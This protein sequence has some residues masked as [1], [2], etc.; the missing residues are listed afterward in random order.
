VD[1]STLSEQ[2]REIIR[3]QGVSKYAISKKTGVS[4]TLISRFLSAERGLSLDSLDKIAAV[5]GIHAVVLV[6]QLPRGAKR[7]R[8]STKKEKGA[9]MQSF[10]PTQ[11]V[12][13]W[14]RVAIRC[15]KDSYENNFASRRGA[16][17]ISNM[18]TQSGHA[19]CIYDNNPYRDFVN[20]RSAWRDEVVESLRIK[21][22]ERGIRQLSY[23]VWP[24]KRGPG[25]GY[26]YAMMVDA[27]EE[28]LDEVISIA[29]ENLKQGYDTRCSVPTQTE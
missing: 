6:Q 8:K 22:E 24:A 28:Q 19:V 7:G 29:V 5:Y 14:Y 25:Y 4:E 21:L 16:Y 23:A 1:V 18:A 15:A 27:S 20:G 10:D 3:G 17:C 12:S 9:S 26:T 13:Y 2:I 11:D